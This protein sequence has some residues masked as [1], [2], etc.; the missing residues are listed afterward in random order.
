LL[1]S[2]RHY[3]Q[4]N[5]GGPELKLAHTDV[6]CV[7]ASG[8]NLSIV[9]EVQVRVKIQGFSWPCVFLVSKRLQGQPIFGVDFIVKAKMVIDICGSRR[10]VGFAPAVS[11][12]FCSSNGPLVCLQMTQPSLSGSP[13]RC[14][15]LSAH[16]RW[17]LENLV[18]KYPDVLTEKLGLTRLLEY[19]IQLLD[20]TLLLK[21][22]FSK[23]TYNSYLGTALS[24]HHALTIL[25]LCF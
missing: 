19:D 18:H 4:L 21:C 14:G 17:K 9:G 24:S 8:Q 3:Q 11:V 13:I 10:Y 20:S 22:N 15:H 1:I 7:T 23:S 25:A 2:F 6:A 12:P 5:Q 16:Q